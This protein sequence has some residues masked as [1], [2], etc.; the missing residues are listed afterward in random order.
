MK[1]LHQLKSILFLTIL[2]IA[3]PLLAQDDTY[4]YGDYGAAKSKKTTPQGFSLEKVTFGGSLGANFG[5]NQ[6]YLEIA[7]QLGYFLTENLLVG[8]GANYTYFEDKQF[9]VST[10]L[11]GSRTFF[12]YVFD[13]L[14]IIAHA[15]GEIINIELFGNSFNTTERVNVYNFYVGGGLKQDLGGSSFLYVLALYNLNETEK[16]RLIQFNPIVRAGIAIGL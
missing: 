8:I 3:V 1:P 9:N 10:S 6:T 16:S 4:V 5:S 2:L 15:E 13:G 14:P 7:P 11:Y 12:Q